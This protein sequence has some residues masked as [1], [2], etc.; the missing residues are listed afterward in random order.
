MR[1][2]RSGFVRIRAIARTGT[3]FLLRGSEAS[4]RGETRRDSYCP[5]SGA[6]R[7]QARE[8]AYDI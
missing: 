5:T 8:F 7:Q 1:A 3:D 4:H 2:G 6:A